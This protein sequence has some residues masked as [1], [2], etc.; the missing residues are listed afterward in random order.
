MKRLVLGGHRG[1]SALLPESLDDY[2]ADTNPVRVVDVFVDK[3]DLGRLGFDGVVPAETGRPAY[4]PDVLLR[5][6]IYGFL[7]HIQS[8]R[9]LEREAPRNVELMWLTGRLMLDFAD[10]SSSEVATRNFQLIGF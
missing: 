9:C 7:H 5:I 1:Q 3:L 2:V 6:Y 10:G 8:S 4:H